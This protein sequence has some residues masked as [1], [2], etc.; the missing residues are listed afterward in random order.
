MAKESGSTY[1]ATI[2][3][4]GVPYVFLQL[5]LPIVGGMELAARVARALKRAPREVDWRDEVRRTIAHHS[6][7]PPPPLT[8]EQR[9]ALRRDGLL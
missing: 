6:T 2:V 7:H 1:V 3:S 9:E 4:I 5:A 8:Q